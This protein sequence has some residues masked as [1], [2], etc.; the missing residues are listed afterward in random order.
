LT[1]HNA[2]RRIRPAI[3]L[4]SAATVLLLVAVSYNF[5]TLARSSPA[6]ALSKE[7]VESPDDSLSVHAY[8]SRAVFT[9]GE[10]IP[11]SIYLI[12][13]TDRVL[14]IRPGLYRERQIEA[15]CRDGYQ[16]VLEHTFPPTPASIMPSD[17]ILPGDSVLTSADLAEDY[18]L[19]R[20]VGESFSMHPLGRFKTQVYLCGRGRTE[21]LPYRVIRPTSV[22]WDVFNWLAAHRIQ[23]LRNE[24]RTYAPALEQLLLDHSTSAYAPQLM[25]LLIQCYATGMVA[26]DAKRVLYGK[27]LAELNPNRKDGGFWFSQ[28]LERMSSTDA[29]E[30]ALKTENDYPGTVIG[31]EAVRYRQRVEKQA[32]ENRPDSMAFRIYLDKTEYLFGE[33]VYLHFFIINLTDDTLHAVEP[34]YFFNVVAVHAFDDYGQEL[35]YTGYESSDSR[36]VCQQRLLPP[37]DTLM[38]YLDLSRRYDQRYLTGDSNVVGQMVGTYTIH[39]VYL[40]RTTS[41]TLR[42]VVNDP[43]GA[44]ADALDLLRSVT[45]SFYHFVDSSLQSNV[46]VLLMR[47]PQSVYAPQVLAQMQGRYRYSQDDNWV[48][49]LQYSRRLISD[50]PEYPGCQAVLTC[51]VQHQSTSENRIFLQG[52]IEA[53]PK[54]WA[55]RYA[56]EWLKRL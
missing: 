38:D 19:H 15:V 27:R 39:A 34:N 45:R 55:A 50:Y 25:S 17:S 12:N 8:M 43:F 54:T 44:E 30:Y 49:L 36:R 53:K 32:A 56:R 21:E 7:P 47:H 41:N 4:S 5:L 48:R 40:N 1:S 18:G 37:H 24:L 52:V 16:S 23:G 10:A 3:I 20:F 2:H 31:R 22:D 13:R 51:I 14:Y 9:Q 42:Y 35:P 46:E 11:L 33:E 6:E 29:I 26:D 28:S